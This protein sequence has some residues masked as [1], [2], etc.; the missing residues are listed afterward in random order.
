MT[1]RVGPKGQVVIPKWLR[2]ELGIKPGDEV[3]FWR[4]G[5]EV[6]LKRYRRPKSLRG[7]LAGTNALETFRAE[8]RWELERE[9]R[10]AGPP[11]R[12]GTA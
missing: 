5:D 2:D 6:H 8:R 7:L 11:R 10:R 3:I 9:E 4:E 1:N 12:P